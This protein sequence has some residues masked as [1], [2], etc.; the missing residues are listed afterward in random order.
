MSQA[1]GF[2]TVLVCAALAVV[3]L[4]SAACAEDDPE[5]VSGGSSGTES[6]EPATEATTPS[7]ETSTPAP[8]TGPSEEVD[9]DSLCRVLPEA[10]AEALI[11]ADLTLG[12]SFEDECDWETE[13]QARFITIERL[14]IPGYDYP[15]A[16]E[17]TASHSDGPWEPVDV[18]DEAYYGWLTPDLSVR[19]G[20]EIYK[21]EI[22]LDELSAELDP[23]SDKEAEKQAL[24]SVAEQALSRL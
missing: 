11:G 13:D 2:R 9:A 6:S 7:T 19:S 18:G 14:D 21:L 15:S 8:P 16:D 17:W 10:E 3:L 22:A 5:I 24:I 20:Q 12:R 4:L 23:E 1:P